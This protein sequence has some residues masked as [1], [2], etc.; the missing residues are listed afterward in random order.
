VT[1]RLLIECGA[2]GTRGAAIVG[3]AVVGFAF[4]PARGDEGLARPLRA[5]DLALG[6]I[7]ALARPLGGAFVDLG[8]DGEG[9]IALAPGEMKEGA[10]LLA[11][12]RR[13]A[14]GPKGPTLDADWRVGA[15]EDEG[16]AVAGLSAETPLGRID[17]KADAAAMVARALGA[18]PG[19]D[20]AVDAPAAAAALARAGLKARIGARL[21]DGA[22]AD[23]ALDEALT[24]EAALP[25]GARL[26][27]DETEGLAVIDVDAAA[28]VAGGGARLA[29][30]INTEVARAIPAELARRRIGGRVVIDF[31]PPSSAAA[32]A[33]LKDLFAAA[34]A[35]VY[36]CR[37]GRLA[38]DGLLDLTAP[39][40]DQSLL[41]EASE[42]V[43]DGL[44]RPGR[45]LRADF[46]AMLAVAGLE[47][48]LAANPS[49]RVAL[50]LGDAL[51]TIILTTRAHWRERL[52]ARFGARFDVTLDARLGPR[53]WAIDE[54][55]R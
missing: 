13:P 54:A 39:R 11:R 42:P 10:R 38:A 47:T 9:F 12:V 46:A 1:R 33:D 16:E 15:S 2:A 27:I 18:R 36:S 28:A 51:A 34:A 20:I 37:I 7:A 24:R 50:R 14:I 19:D 52:A 26:V 53:D 30:R 6:R 21:F 25:S 4:A 45:R 35:P 5:G 44:M 22:G 43:A 41:E 55:P 17:A 31:L 40:S 49:A 29:D 32:R 48:R 3:D 23:A 8:R